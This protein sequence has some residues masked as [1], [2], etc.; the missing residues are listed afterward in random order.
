MISPSNCGKSKFNY[1]LFNFCL[2]CSYLLFYFLIIHKIQVKLLCLRSYYPF[3]FFSI[4]E[5]QSKS[6]R[7]SWGHPEA[8]PPGTPPPPYPSLTNADEVH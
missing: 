7:G 5:R 2:Y 1:L 6:S 3:F 8:T 4:A